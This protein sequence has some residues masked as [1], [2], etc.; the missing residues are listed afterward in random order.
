MVDTTEGGQ[1]CIRFLKENQLGRV[2]VIV[3]DQVRASITFTVSFIWYDL[4]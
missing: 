4:C 3:L 1:A 2:T